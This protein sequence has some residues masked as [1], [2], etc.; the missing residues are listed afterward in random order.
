MLNKNDIQLINEDK[1]LDFHKK[2]TETLCEMM[3]NHPV[4][5]SV[6]EQIDDMDAIC[7]AL[8]GCAP[9]DN[10]YM[11]EKNCNDTDNDE[12][13][14]DEQKDYKKIKKNEDDDDE[15]DED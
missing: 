15:D 9:E 7:Q 10:V 6:R 4:F 2:V 8:D 1:Y 11:H 12:D 14:D 13:D 5:Q 3:I